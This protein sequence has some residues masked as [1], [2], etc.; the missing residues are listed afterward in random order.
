MPNF[1]RVE[2]LKRVFRAEDREELLVAIFLV[3]MDRNQSMKLSACRLVADLQTL[4]RLTDRLRKDDLWR[5]DLLQTNGL[6]RVTT[7]SDDA[8]FTSTLIR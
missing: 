6:R 8:S 1:R 4:C 7:S 3:H 5:T 2:W